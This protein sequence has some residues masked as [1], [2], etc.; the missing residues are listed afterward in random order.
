MHYFAIRPDEVE[1]LSG[2]PFFMRSPN[3]P[4][5]FTTP[6]LF[7]CPSGL[8][9]FWLRIENPAAHTR[10]YLQLSLLEHSC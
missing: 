2:L 3:D 7:V 6:C 8:H 10:L 4:L 5:S 9:S 1:A